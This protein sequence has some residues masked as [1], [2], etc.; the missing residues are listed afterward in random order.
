M[1]FDRIINNVSDLLQ[2]FPGIR[3]AN[4]LL[5]YRGHGR[6][7]WQLLPHVMR[8]PH[9][10]EMEAGLTTRFRQN[11]ISFL[12]SREYNWWD[13]LLYMQHFDV[14]TRLL[15]WSENPLVGLYFAVANERHHDVDGCLWALDPK[16][17]NR[18]SRMAPDLGEGI[19]CLGIDAVLEDYSPQKVLL[20][21][22]TGRPPAAV[23]AMR[24]FPRLFAQA[25]VFTITHQDAMPLEDIE[26]GS[27]VGRFII[28]AAVKPNIRNELLHL[29]I[30]QLSLFPELQS[31]AS[32]TVEGIR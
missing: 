31:V 18:F 15:D 22:A 7:E 10:R 11:A 20:G 8:P 9:R 13:W 2:A 27:H 3:A 5:W 30:N 26:D 1:L 6:V 23:V 4:P 28:P 32:V 24:L 29:G 12:P 21:P 19:P 16:S 17:L 25:G 14:P